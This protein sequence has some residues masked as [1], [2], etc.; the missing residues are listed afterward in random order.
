MLPRIARYFVPRKRNWQWLI[1]VPLGFL[2]VFF[3]GIACTQWAPANYFERKSH[4]LFHVFEWFDEGH[5]VYPL[6]DFLIIYVDDLSQKELQQPWDRPWDRKLHAD[7]L[8]KIR[9]DEPQ[10]VFYD[11]VFDMPS[12]DAEADADFEAEIA[13][14]GK[15]VLGASNQR[16]YFPGNA[17]PAEQLFVPYAPFRRAAAAW[18]V[19]Q[20]HYDYADNGLRW[21]HRVHGDDRFKPAF[22]NAAQLIAP[23]IVATAGPVEQPRWVR[24]FGPSSTIPNLSFYTALLDEQISFKNKLV[25]IGARHSVAMPGAGRDVYRSPYLRDSEGEM[26][27]VEMQATMVRNL[28]TESWFDWADHGTLLAIVLISTL[29]LTLIVNTLGARL[30][31]VGCLCFILC[32]AIFSIWWIHSQGIFFAW[33]VPAFVQ[34]PVAF[35]YSAICN[36]CFLERKRNRLK[37]IFA[38][39]LSPVMV[40]RIADAEEE[41]QLGGEEANIT[42]FFSDVADYS[43]FSELLSPMDLTQL[44]NEYLGA[45][46]DVLQDEGGTLDKYVGDAIVAIFGAPLHTADHAYKACRSAVRM[47]Q[48]QEELRQRWSQDKGRWP[49]TVCQMRTRIGLNTGHAVVGNMGSTIRFNYSMSG[50][51]VNLAARCE[52]SAKHFGVYTMVTQAT[53]DAA[54]EIENHGLVFRRINRCTVLGRKEPVTFYELMG[55]EAD[56]SDRQLQCREYYEHALAAYLRRDWARAVEYLNQSIPLERFQARSEPHIMLNPSLLLMQT[57]QNYMNQAPPVDW[58]GVYN[59]PSK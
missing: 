56:M 30:S 6:E 43:K 51:S 50:D 53:R 22:W 2:F 29:L 49:E 59:L 39:Y 27:G 11:M 48:V 26:T 24:L 42:P 15:V 12:S 44:M 20:K 46:T 18:G 23:E 8:H 4:D 54:S 41:P 25:F 57:C 55:F 58:D 32:S 40:E 5:P 35:G 13:A 47:Q 33:L 38:S 28:L 19:V 10:L 37:R 45:M 31:L 9:Q 36:Y 34:A 14:C 52:S 1:Q 7:L 17:E 3:V 21:M 16:Y